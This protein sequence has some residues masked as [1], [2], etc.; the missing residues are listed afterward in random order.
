MVDLCIGGGSFKG[1][2]F[3][4]ALQ[5][6]YCKGYIDHIQNFY[7]CSVGSIIGILYIIGFKPTEILEELLIIEFSKFWKPNLKTLDEKYAILGTDFFIYLTELFLKK[8][9]KDITIKEFNKK[10]ITNINLLAF[11]VTA[12][13]SVNFNEQE[14]QNIKVIDAVKASCSIPIIFPP[15]KINEEYYVDGCLSGSMLHTEKIKG[16][17]IKLSPN[18]FIFHSDTFTDY[19]MQI[20]TLATIKKTSTDNRNTIKIKVMK[21]YQSR[22]NFSNLTNN[23]KIIL[24]YSGIKQAAE[25]IP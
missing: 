7:G 21:E 13:K 11:N 14:Y 1:L 24:Y 17:T 12:K 5:Y 16:Y 3:L 19:V 6:L 4:G 10:Y 8:E 20:L 2:A 9:N 22:L 15:I 18:E 25:T 23:D